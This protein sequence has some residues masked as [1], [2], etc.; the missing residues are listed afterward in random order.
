M[1]IHIHKRKLPLFNV[2]INNNKLAD[3]VINTRFIYNQLGVES[4]ASLERVNVVYGIPK[5]LTEL[6]TKPL[7][8]SMYE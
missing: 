8:E 4:L 1:P 5:S 3:G 2:L 6:R 7:K